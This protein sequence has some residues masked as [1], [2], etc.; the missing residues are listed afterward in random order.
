MFTVEQSQALARHL[1]RSAHEEPVSVDKDGRMVLVVAKDDT[2]VDLKSLAREL[3]HGPVQLRQ[4][5][6][7]RRSA[8]RHAGLGDAVCADQCVGGARSRSWSTKALMTSTSE[9]SS[10]SRIPPR[11][12]FEPKTSSASSRLAGTSP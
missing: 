8:R 12:G 6:A 5:G 10:R 1:A 2:R 9:C 11:R 3:G 7:A 4:G